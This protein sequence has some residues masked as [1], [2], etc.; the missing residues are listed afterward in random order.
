M[1]GYEIRDPVFGFIKFNGW[2]K[3]IIDHPIFQRLR[4]IRQLALTD[5]VY[6]GAIH[7]RFEHSLGVMHLA[8]RMYDAII[9]DDFN[10]QLLKE[11]LNY[12]TSGLQ[13]D[14]QLVR[15]AALLHDVGHFPFSHASENILKKN[16]KTKKPYKHEDYTTALIN[17]PLRD[18]IEKHSI[19][20]TN[21]SITADDISGLI[22][23]NPERLR[24]RVFW[25]VIISSQLDADRGDYLLRDSY[26]SGVKYGIYDLD[27]LLVTIALGIDPETND[28]IL[29]V[30][31]GGW[32]VAESL[33]IARYLMFSQVYFHK[34]RRAYD[35]MLQEAIKSS[36][37]TLPS[38]NKIEA[39]L[40]LDD[41]VMWHLMKNKNDNF[42]CNSIMTRNHLRR[43]YETGEFPTLEDEDML[44]K[45]KAKLDF[46]GIWYLEDMAMN[47]WY[48]LNKDERGR[49]EIMIIGRDKSTTPL[50]KYSRIVKNLGISR[51]IRLYIKPEDREKAEKMIKGASNEREHL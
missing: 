18:V 35:Y 29:G 42:W 19:N 24:E 38:P 37:K 4:R 50:L 10:K 22:E 16:P 15:L 51:Q 49:E 13:R 8:T 14:R 1:K 5:M 44:G 26:H 31:E 46:E 25:K 3:E 9:S 20:R 48:K 23:G 34:T 30:K 2:E 6:P 45:I 21:F 40:E 28:V 32:H 17:G 41:Y 47:V 33:I 7:T 27:R 43:V 39:F 11:K 36:V 12:E